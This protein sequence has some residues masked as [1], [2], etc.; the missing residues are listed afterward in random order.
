MSNLLE[1]LSPSGRFIATI[2]LDGTLAELHAAR[3]R[4]APLK[5]P[6]GRMPTYEEALDALRAAGLSIGYAAEERRRAHLAGA[7]DVLRMVHDLGLSGGHVSRSHAPLNRRELNE[8]VREYDFNYREP[9][10]SVRVSYHVGFF[11]ARRET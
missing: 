10:G 8:L 2:M 1:Q 6:A 5:P 4:A 9:D 11:V 3:L 7:Q